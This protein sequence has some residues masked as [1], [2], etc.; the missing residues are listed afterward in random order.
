MA[1]AHPTRSSP[2]AA[3]VA[4]LVREASLEINDLELRD[5]DAARELLA[6]GRRVFVSHLPGQSWTRTF[7][8][9]ALVARRGLEPVPH[10]PVRLLRDHAEWSALLRQARDAG[11]QEP[12]LISGDY[13]RAC[14]PFPSVLDVLETGELE[15]HGFAR[16][17]FA[18]HP[19]G[20]P[21]VAS[22]VI[23]DAQLEK[24]CRATALGIEVTFVTQFFFDAGAFEQWALE[25]R[26][27]GVRAR[28]VAGIAGPVGL[29]KL[30]RL[31]QRCGV[32]RSLRALT[33]RPASALKL[34]ADHDP[35]GLLRE[36]VGRTAG[37]TPD[38]IHL[39]SFGGLV[40]TAEWL[41]RRAR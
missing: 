19:E 11:V 4:Q 10:I 1:S 30:V 28:L 24:W 41:A 36:L 21:A 32:G 25:L 6:P 26:N 13:P 15:K 8:M 38:G 23:R 17:S 5:L 27:A 39:F 22:T 18:G 31:A 16:V 35:A 33:A 3:R 12:L 37:G 9:C 2:Q 34:L 14:G 29:G 7:E 20:H 40:R